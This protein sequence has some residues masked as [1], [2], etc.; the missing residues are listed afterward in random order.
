MLWMSG[1]KVFE[2]CKIS[3]WTI[4]HIVPMTEAFTSLFEEQIHQCKSSAVLNYHLSD[5]KLSLSVAI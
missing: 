3:R 1:C 5:A 4:H 2:N